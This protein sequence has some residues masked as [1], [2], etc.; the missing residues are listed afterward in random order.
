MLRKTVFLL[1]LL[2]GLA[3]GV[4]SASVDIGPLFPPCYPCG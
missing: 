2:G 1:L 4:G 3:P